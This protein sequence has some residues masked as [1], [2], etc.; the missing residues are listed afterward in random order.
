MPLWKIQAAY[1]PKDLTEEHVRTGRLVGMLESWYPTYVGYHFYY[2]SRRRTS[3]A[4]SV[5]IDALKQSY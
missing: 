4:V 1:L 3:T 5:V 2:A